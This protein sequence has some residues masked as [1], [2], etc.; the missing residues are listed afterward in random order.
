[1]VGRRWGAPVGRGERVFENSRWA[2]VCVAENRRSWLLVGSVITKSPPRPGAHN[3]IIADLAMPVVPAH[4]AGGHGCAVYSSSVTDAQWAI[5][6]PL[7]AAP[8]STAGRGGRPEKHCC[9]VIVEAILYIVRGGIAWRQLPMEFP[10]AGTVSAVFARWA[11]GGAWQCILDALRDRLRVAAGRDRWPERG[12]HRFAD[13]TRRRHR[14]PIQPRLGWRQENQ[15]RQAAPRRGGERPAARRR[16]HRRLDPRPRRR[17]PTPGRTAR[18]LLHH[19][20]GL[21]RRRLPRTV[22]HLGERRSHPC[23]ADHHTPPGATGFHVRPRIWVVERSFAWINTHRRCAR[24]YE[25]RPDHH[26]AMVHLAMITTMTR[27]LA[28]T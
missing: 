16:R 28:R 24:D 27:R 12:D 2:G 9:R 26:E 11:R 6:E 25:T 8:G 14:A 13:G 5:L 19:R 17:T 7:L 20:A 10:P 15:R 18:Q 4:A 1:M 3:A 22:A 23:S 21:G